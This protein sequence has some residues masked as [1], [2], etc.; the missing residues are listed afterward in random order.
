MFFPI[1]SR[2]AELLLLKSEAAA[3]L[4]FSLADLSD[5]GAGFGWTEVAATDTPQVTVQLMGLAEGGHR[6]RLKAQDD[7][8][9]TF[10][11]NSA[12][13][14]RVDVTPPDS[15]V[16]EQPKSPLRSS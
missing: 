1:N 15:E 8:G 14:W 11:N 16:V 10:V 4:W 12:W 13:A 9:N 6:L 2:S 5:G 3:R 7:L